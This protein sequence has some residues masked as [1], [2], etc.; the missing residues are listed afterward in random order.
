[1]IGQATTYPLHALRALA[2]HSQAL[3]TANGSEPAATPD[4]IHNV[5]QQ[6]GCVQIDTLQ[7]VQRSHY[8][9]IWSRLG[10]YDPAD[11]D[12]LIYAEPRRLFEDWLHAACIVP[13]TEYRYRLPHKSRLRNRPAIWTERWLSE[14]G[15]RELLAATLQRVRD[16]G[17]VAVS[18]FDYDGPKRGS[19]WDW[20]PVKHALENL[21]A[22]GD[23]MIA[24]RVRF[25]R[26]YDL[27]ER[28]LPD[29]VDRRE[30]T[31]AEMIRHTMGMAARAFGVC[32]AKQVANYI[33]EVSRTEAEPHVQSLLAEGLLVQVQGVFSDGMVQ[34]V[35]V[36][37]D[38][39]PLLQQAADGALTAQRTTFLSPFDSLFWAQRRDVQLWGFRQSLEAYLPAPKRQ[40]GYFCLPIL[41]KDRLVG[42]F[43]PKLERS[44]GTLRLKALHLEP[45]VAPSPELL[46][47]IAIA[48]RDFMAFH[49]AHDLVIEQSTP[50]EAGDRLLAAL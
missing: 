16:G 2:L 44:N 5:V 29:W 40:Y 24:N 41:H 37:R 30:P 38:N 27:T 14:P 32:Q 34:D 43:D 11:F 39:L 23:L 10:R 20:K 1:M 12:H 50:A 3:T 17:A 46:A 4:A 45:D 35:L 7:M 19:W 31:R 13:L 49:G 42:R 25:R 26:V 6:L 21:F 48:M 28:V 47:D 22:W 9:A 15:S 33:H 36:H 18:D 8:L